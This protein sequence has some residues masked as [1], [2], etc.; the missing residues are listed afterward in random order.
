MVTMAVIALIIWAISLCNSLK[1]RVGVIK[2]GF[3]LFIAVIFG[4]FLGGFIS[5]MIGIFFIPKTSVLTNTEVLEPVVVGGKEK[6]LIGRVNFNPWSGTS[7]YVYFTKN[8]QGET[9]EYA[10]ELKNEIIVFK[11]GER[12]KQV[13]SE[14]FTNKRLGW[15][16]F[17]NGNKKVRFILS[18]EEDIF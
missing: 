12:S 14:F 16:F 5:L 7:A 18:S 13:L 9:E 3:N 17:G 11:K 1:K 8:K 10:I 6:F 15:F 2:L 4:T